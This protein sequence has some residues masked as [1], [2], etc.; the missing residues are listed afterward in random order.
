MRRGI[1]PELR[2]TVLNLKAVI[3]SA[4]LQLSACSASDNPERATSPCPM[5]GLGRSDVTLYD[6]AGNQISRELKTS[7]GSCIKYYF[8]KNTKY[9]YLQEY[10]NK[11]G[12]F[13]KYNGY[14]NN[15]KSYYYVNIFDNGKSIEKRTISVSVD[16]NG[17]IF[18]VITTE[19]WLG[20]S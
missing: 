1:W 15:Y 5:R 2:I 18:D 3:I 17:L 6:K 7:W 20:N 14:K 12:F 11:S 8:Q 16:D 9:I 10:A 19:N 13:Y 4:L